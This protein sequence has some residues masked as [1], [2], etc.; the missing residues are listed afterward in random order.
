MSSQSENTKLIVYEAHRVRQIVDSLLTSTTPVSAIG[1]LIS[2]A[3]SPVAA[4]FERY[5]GLV[6]RDAGANELAELP[7]SCT[8]LLS[9]PGEARLARL[10]TTSDL[11]DS[12]HNLL[13]CV[14]DAL[15]RLCCIA[16]S[17]EDAASVGMSAPLGIGICSLGSGFLGN[18]TGYRSA[19]MQLPPIGRAEAPDMAYF[20]EIDWRVLDYTAATAH[21]VFQSSVLPNMHQAFMGASGPDGSDWD[22]RT[23]L[24][25]ILETLELPLR[26][27]YR[28]DVNVQSQAVSVA[29]TL[30]SLASLPAQAPSESDRS[31]VKLADRRNDARAVYG[32][33]LCCLIAA[34]A[35]GSGRHLERA[36]VTA[37]RPDDAKPVIACAFSRKQFVY[38]T[39]TAIDSRKLLDPSLRFDVEEVARLAA[40]DYLSLAP[41][42][43]DEHAVLPD[44]G[45]AALRVEPHLDDRGL[46]HNMQQLFHAQRICDI[47][48]QHYHGFGAEAV[49]EAQADSADSTI[50]AIANLEHIVAEL[51]HDTVPPGDNADARP[52]YCTNPLARAVVTLL[53]DELDVGMQA[54]AFLHGEEDGATKSKSSVEYF[55]APDALFHAHMGLSDLYERLGDVRGAEAEADRCI[56]LAPTSAMSYFRKSDVLA[57]QGRFAEAANL[58]L[59]GLR[60]AAS[61]R[62]CALL[63]YH[64][65]LILWNTDRKREAVAVHVYTASLAGE[66]AEKASRVVQSLRKRGDSPVI[67]YASPLAAAREM[68]R[69]RI[70]VAPSDAARTL[71][72]KAT[73]GLSCANAPEAC[74]PYAAAMATYFRD[75][76]TIAA[77]CR[78]LIHGVK[79]CRSS[80]D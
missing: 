70:P 4:P 60:C 8:V 11:D 25:R 66:Y 20:N 38:E 65:A 52:L 79:M 43:G 45:M 41:F 28:F 78:S 75:D 27:G 13:V 80:D 36:Y 2:R 9:P 68:N 69:A 32:L 24:A 61:P 3:G 44:D 73:V 35:F 58:L 71:I 51:E 49:T 50:A 63:Y 34:A 55:R 57:Q 19:L 16:D 33:R 74:A 59:A 14:E 56:A 5:A 10:T 67:V 42:D 15:N 46:P 17:I 53:D 12:Q 39:L 76:R 22:V 64:L 1:A 47:D 7:P 23:R 48:T 6:L 40:P 54:E 37:V 72:V 26:Y 21:S 31:L 62:D 29:I 30:P 18:S 77:T